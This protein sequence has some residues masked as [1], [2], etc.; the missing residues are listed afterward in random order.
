VGRAVGFEI[1]TVSIRPGH[2][3]EGITIARGRHGNGGELAAIPW[4]INPD[5]GPVV[6]ELHYILAGRVA[7]ALAFGTGRV[8]G[9]DPDRARL[10]FDALPVAKRTSLLNA[11]VE[12]EGTSDEARAWALAADFCGPDAKAVLDLVYPGIKRFVSDR[13]AP[14]FAVATELQAGSVLDGP[15]IDTIL[16]VGENVDL[17]DGARHPAHG[18]PSRRYS[19][20]RSTRLPAKAKR[21]RITMPGCNV[22]PRCSYVPMHLPTCSRR[23][24]AIIATRPRHRRRRI[25]GGSLSQALAWSVS[26]SRPDRGPHRRG[27]P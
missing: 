2:C 9:P 12:T 17:A 6:R 7:E 3:H 20:A 15:A 27:H 5:L 14:I 22:P 18:R 8:A 21:I 25:A 26:H 1:L 16:A 23:R 11:E 24:S 10:A 4:W 13:A 19:S